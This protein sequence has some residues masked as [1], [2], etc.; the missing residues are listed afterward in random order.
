MNIKSCVIAEHL[1]NMEKFTAVHPVIY[2]IDTIAKGQYLAHEKLKML[3]I[4]YAFTYPFTVETNSNNSIIIYRA[5][6]KK[7]IHIHI[8]IELTEDE[9]QTLIKERIT[10]K[11]W[12]P[13]APIMKI[14]FRK[15]HTLLFQ[16]INQQA[17]LQ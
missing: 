12:L 6:V 15:Q 4:P 2:K 13:I 10:F 3:F 14:I 5:F 9:E 11:S 8:R 1:I 16:N 17:T 7:I